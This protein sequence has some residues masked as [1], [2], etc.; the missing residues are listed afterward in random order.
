MKKP[1]KRRPAMEAD[2]AKVLGRRIRE[3]RKKLDLKQ[4]QL[5]AELGVGSPQIISQI[6]QVKRK[7]DGHKIIRSYSTCDQL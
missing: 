3:L 1:L 2:P 5:A 6:E 7:R 4:E